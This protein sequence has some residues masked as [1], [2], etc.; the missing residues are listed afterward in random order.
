MFP[1]WCV[2]L[3]RQSLALRLNRCLRLSQL[4]Q[5]ETLRTFDDISSCC[6]NVFHGDR[7]SRKLRHIA[8]SHKLPTLPTQTVMHAAPQWW[9][10]WQQKKTC[11][12]RWVRFRL[13]WI[14]HKCTHVTR[15]TCEKGVSRVWRVLSGPSVLIGQGELRCWEKWKLFKL[16]W[17]SR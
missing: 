13:I 11:I 14:Y 6:G 2:S 12:L 4:V 5:G 8:Y 15:Y 10:K 16:I 17:C 7:L 1:E 9:S 3:Y